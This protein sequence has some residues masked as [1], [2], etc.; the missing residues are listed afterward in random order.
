MNDDFEK[1]LQHQPLRKIPFDWRQQIL[2]DASSSQPSTLDPRPSFLSTLNSKLS[3]ILWPNPKAWAGLAAAWVVIFALQ[4][5]SRSSSRM[6]ATAR[7]PK[8]PVFLMTLKDQQQMLV[9][10]MGNNQ[11][12]DA[13]QPRRTG[14]QPRSE[15]RNPFL[16]A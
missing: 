5:A 10:L 11:S 13:D 3:T 16:T 9:E 12:T 7:A 2:Q 15:L 6:V 1:R 14:P 8:S 4:F